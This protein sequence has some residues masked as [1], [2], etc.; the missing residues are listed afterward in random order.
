MTLYTS[1]SLPE[2]LNL[3]RSDVMAFFDGKAYADWI[4]QQEIESKNIVGICERLNEV[5]RGL[6]IH[7]K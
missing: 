3:P 5:I 4:K 1:T 7:Q 6:S 2:A